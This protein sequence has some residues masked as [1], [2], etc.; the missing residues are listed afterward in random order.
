MDVD[1]DEA[2]HRDG[3]GRGAKQR[4]PKKADATVEDR[5]VI[6]KQQRK[7]IDTLETD[8]PQLM[9]LYNGKFRSLHEKNNEIFDNV[10]HT[11]EQLNDA[12]IFNRESL[13]IRAAAQNAD[14]ISKRYDFSSYAQSLTAR[15]NEQGGCCHFRG[16]ASPLIAPSHAILAGSGDFSWCAFGQD[17]GGLFL[18]VPPMAVML[19]P[20]GK[21]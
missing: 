21:V 8:A 11:R 20:M 9:Q 18:S 3:G 1:D 19:G 4:L 5:R 2:G 13:V 16:C 7:V 14:D 15:F 10:T 6:R 12:E 17:I